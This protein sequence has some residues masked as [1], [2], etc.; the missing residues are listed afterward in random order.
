MKQGVM[1][2]S[3]YHV[4]PDNVIVMLLLFNCLWVIKV[5][6]TDCWKRCKWLPIMSFLP[7]LKCFKMNLF[8]LFVCHCFDHTPI[9]SYPYRQSSP[10]ENALW[11][12][13]CCFQNNSFAA[14]YRRSKHSR[15]RPW[16]RKAQFWSNAA[17]YRS[18]RGFPEK[19]RA[20][21]K[22][23]IISLCQTKNQN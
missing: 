19:A 1:P 3:G 20:G 2:L 23:I 4:L 9:I 14:F 18:K 21:A 6:D 22:S 11:L 15:L 16:C 7:F 5:L 10:S 8:E 17:I 12:R 13:P